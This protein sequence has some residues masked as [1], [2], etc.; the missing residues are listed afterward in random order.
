[1]CWRL[2]AEH[3]LA[4]LDLPWIH[5]DPFARLLVVQAQLEGLRLCTADRRLLEYGQAVSMGGPSPGSLAHS[6]TTPSV[7]I[8]AC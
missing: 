7:A 8:P 2:Q 5:R 4:A 3:V 1:M 6:S